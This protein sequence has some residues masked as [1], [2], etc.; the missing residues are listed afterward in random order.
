MKTIFSAT[1]DGDEISPRRR[2][3]S[4]WSSRS[5]DIAAAASS[6]PARPRLTSS[7]PAKPNADSGSRPCAPSVTSSWIGARIAFAAG[8]ARSRL[9]CV[10]S[11]KLISG[12]SRPA[13]SV[14]ARL[15]QLLLDV[16]HQHAAAAQP[17]GVAAAAEDADPA[18]LDHQV[19]QPQHLVDVADRQALVQAEHGGL[20]AARDRLGRIGDRRL[21]ATPIRGWR[22]PDCRS[23]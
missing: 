21:A 2:R 22:T 8:L 16:Q 1:S 13:A 23:A 15:A 18:A 3:A 6:T 9:A 11:M 20:E 12:P 7:A 17:E 10:S 14:L 5:E 4:A 19:D